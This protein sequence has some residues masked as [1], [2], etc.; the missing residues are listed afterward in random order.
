M[1]E[2][3]PSKRPAGSAESRSTVVKRSKTGVAMEEARRLESMRSGAD[4][5]LKG[6]RKE[7]EDEDGGGANVQ[8]QVNGT[9]YESMEFVTPAGDVLD[10]TG[11]AVQEKDCRL[12]EKIALPRRCQPCLDQEA[13]WLEH[14]VLDKG[15]ECSFQGF[16]AVREDGGKE[17]VVDAY[18]QGP[19][20]KDAD[21]FRDM[22]R[23]SG[24]PDADETLYSEF[25]ICLVKMAEAVLPMIEE[26]LE[27]ATQIERQVFLQP[28]SIDDL[29]PC[30]GC[31]SF[32]IGSWLCSR[33]G[34]DLC[35]QCFAAV[36]QASETGSITLVRRGNVRACRRSH[37]DRWI[38]HQAANF[39]PISR[40]PPT[41]WTTARMLA[42]HAKILY[43]PGCDYLVKKTL[44][45][46]RRS[47]DETAQEPWSRTMAGEEDLLGTLC[48]TVGKEMTEEE[49]Y[50]EVLRT[51]LVIHEPFLVRQCDW[52]PLTDDDLAALFPADTKVPVRLVWHG[53]EATEETVTWTWTEVAEE[54]S[55][56]T[57]RVLWMDVRDFPKEAD[58]EKLS[59]KACS[60]FRRASCFPHPANDEDGGI[61]DKVKALGDVAVWANLAGRDAREK[62]YAASECEDEGLGM[63][64]TSLHVDE[65]G[66]ANTLLW[67]GGEDQ[68]IHGDNDLEDRTVGAEWLCWPAE[69]LDHFEPAAEACKLE[70]TVDTWEGRVLFGN[71]FTANAAFVNKVVKLGG[72]RCRAQVIHQ[73]V[74]E[75][76]YI[77]AGV[78]H[79]VTNLRPCFKVA[80]DV[81]VPSQARQILHVQRRAVAA[82]AD[83]RFSG[84]D[85]CMVRPCLYKAWR[86]C[87]GFVLRTK[88]DGRKETSNA[89]MY[90]NEMARMREDERVRHRKM[91]DELK[92]ALER[93]EALEARPVESFTKQGLCDML[94]AMLDKAREG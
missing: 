66:A 47:R 36:Q 92:G 19:L 85:A 48:L 22:A 86:A 61:L 25:G 3:G 65:A 9:G 43:R 34:G 16:R 11:L 73:R 91:G 28:T 58:L 63:D 75:T 90:V 68:E 93:I 39:L 6:E 83:G 5:N 79:Q 23:A 15:L 38:P 27:H 49:R 12:D 20:M 29:H 26:E 71:T 18:A 7:D 4:T 13:H 67:V 77:A 45:R 80:R 24:L 54:L 64:T 21:A 76:V 32:L 55:G 72:E 70:G 50:L 81:M 59:E 35:L 69:A 10:G 57:D 31:Q 8:D 44:K 52:S 62:C 17:Y 87:A 89:S 1:T 2:S 84:R 74:G 51:S 82:C 41:E 56:R 30:S 94:Q 78:A 33:C 46:L 53:K 37:S 40:R 14:A 42:H 60:Y 88:F